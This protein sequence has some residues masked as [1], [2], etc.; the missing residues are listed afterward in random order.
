MVAFEDVDSEVEEVDEED[1][2][3]KQ[4]NRDLCALAPASLEARC[5][6]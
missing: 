2:A 3:S 6:A 5:E 4:D 1:K